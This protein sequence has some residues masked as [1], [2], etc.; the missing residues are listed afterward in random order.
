MESLAAESMQGL[1]ST[2]L[3]LGVTSAL[4]LILGMIGLFGVLSYAVARRTREIG[5]RMALGADA[6]RVRALVVGQGIRVVAVGIL[7]GLVMAWVASGVLRG[8]LYGVEPGDPLTFGGVAVAMLGVGAL[9]SW[10]PAWRASRVQPVES[11]NE[12]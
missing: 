9:A 5:V 4:A 2:L 6:G 11:L 10:I 7:G 8:M 1:T 12:A 3:I